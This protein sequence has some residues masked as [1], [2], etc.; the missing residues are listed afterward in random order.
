M[1]EILNE[2]TALYESKAGRYFSEARREIDE[3]V[4]DRIGRVL[5]IGCGSGGTLK[6]LRASRKIDYALGIE[7]VPEAAALAK[8]VFDRVEVGNVE[9]FPLT[10]LEPQSFD[11]IL[12]LDVL[13]HLADPATVVR[14][15]RELLIPGG[16]LIVS[17]PNVS[18]YSVAFPLFLRGHWRYTEEG[19][20]DRTHLR[21]FVEKTA[22]ELIASAGLSIDGIKRNQIVCRWMNRWPD[23]LLGRHIRWYS[24]RLLCLVLPSHWVDY[25]FII[26]ALRRSRDATN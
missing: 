21:F 12:A 13:E 20:L 16:R 15:L 11:L 9:T 1:S 22:V 19:L 7:L 2:R 25:Q 26:S 8:L 24:Q 23:R 5:E 6:H 18:H 4:P 3:F 14:K 10:D 17:I